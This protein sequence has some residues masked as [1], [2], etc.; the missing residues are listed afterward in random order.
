[1][2][3]L[4]INL[5]KSEVVYEAETKGL[6]NQWLLNNFVEKKYSRDAAVANSFKCPYKILVVN[7]NKIEVI[8]GGNNHE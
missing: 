6:C 2:T 8:K 1:M 7:R 3:Y 5:D 4:V